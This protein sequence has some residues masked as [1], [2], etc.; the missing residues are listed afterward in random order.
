MPLN[1]KMVLLSG[2]FNVFISCS[3]LYS[4]NPHVGNNESCKYLIAALIYNNIETG[5]PRW[6]LLIRLKGLHRRSF[7]LILDWILYN[8]LERYG[9]ICS[10][11]QTY[12]GQRK[13][14]PNPKQINDSCLLSVLD[15]NYVMYDGKCVQHSFF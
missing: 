2:I 12:E 1:K 11:N 15:I 3:Y 9:W 5:Y 4:F 6:T 10:H 7:S 13:Y 8:Q 14:D